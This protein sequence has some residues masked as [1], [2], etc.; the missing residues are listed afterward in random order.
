[1]FRIQANPNLLDQMVDQVTEVLRRRRNVAYKAKDNFSLQTAEQ[2][3][4]EFHN[5]MGMVAL[6]TVGLSSI[7][8]LLGGAGV[9]SIMLVSVTDRTREIGIRKAIGAKSGDIT[10]QF[11]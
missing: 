2:Q 4:E 10:W 5:I 11:L 7:G 6:A 9:L 1:M 3:V 8:L